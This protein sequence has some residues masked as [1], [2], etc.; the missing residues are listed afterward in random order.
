MPHIYNKDAKAFGFQEF[1]ALKVLRDGFLVN[2]ILTL[3]VL[4][5]VSPPAQV[6]VSPAPLAL[7]GNDSENSVLGWVGLENPGAS[8]NQ[9]TCNLNTRLQ[10]LFHIPYFR[11]VRPLVR[12]LMRIPYAT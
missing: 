5:S 8:Q 3:S 4:V 11:K 2:D 10:M 9:G 7:V 1:V 6:V 12:H